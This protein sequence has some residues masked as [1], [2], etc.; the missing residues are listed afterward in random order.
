MQTNFDQL[1]D[2]GLVKQKQML[3]PIGPVPCADSTLWSWV[4]AGRFPAPIK[5]DGIRMTCWRVGDV[6]TWLAKQSAQKVAA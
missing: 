4:K 5:I 1:P 2:S 6:R 3:Y